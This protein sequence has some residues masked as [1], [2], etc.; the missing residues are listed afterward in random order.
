M[1]CFCN[2]F[3]IHNDFIAKTNCTVI[4]ICAFQE[5]REFERD[6]KKLEQ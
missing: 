2:I 3:G 6:V 5:E 4:V 1:F